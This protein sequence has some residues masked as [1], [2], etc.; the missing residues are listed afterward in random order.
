MNSLPQDVVNRI[1]DYIDCRNVHRKRMSQVCLDLD[2]NKRPWREFR[3]YWAD[4]YLEATDADTQFFCICILIY[5]PETGWRR[6]SVNSASLF[7]GYLYDGSPA[8]SVVHVQR[9]GEKEGFDWDYSGDTWW[10]PD[11]T[12]YASWY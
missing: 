12:Y 1:Y 7:A 6:A 9:E 4:Q 5:D 11:D 3:A 2:T 8:H 10:K